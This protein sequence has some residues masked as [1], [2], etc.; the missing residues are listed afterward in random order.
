MVRGQQMSQIKLYF[1][2]IPAENAG[3]ESARLDPF[4]MGEVYNMSR[5]LQVHVLPPSHQH[6]EPVSLSWEMWQIRVI[7]CDL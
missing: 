4:S 5:A 2:Y 6:Q 3:G 7:V 1:Q